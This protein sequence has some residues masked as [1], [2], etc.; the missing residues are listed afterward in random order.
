MGR[1]LGRT[2]NFARNADLHPL[3]RKSAASAAMSAAQGTIS[4]EIADA[5]WYQLLSL[6]YDLRN[7]LFHLRCNRPLY[8]KRQRPQQPRVSASTS[9]S[10]L[11]I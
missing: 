8:N 1:K 2:K 9:L 4:V 3:S 10:S 6:N 11:Q 7:L 5:S